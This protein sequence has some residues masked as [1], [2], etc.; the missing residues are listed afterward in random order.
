MEKHLVWSPLKPEKDYDGVRGKKECL[1]V[2][3]L[4]N[5]KFVI[6]SVWLWAW[7]WVWV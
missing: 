3:K 6:S 7:A 4:L 1:P 2:G 5:R